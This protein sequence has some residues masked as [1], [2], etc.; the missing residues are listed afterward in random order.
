MWLGSAVILAALSSAPGA[1]FADEVRLIDAHSQADHE[2]DLDR[3]VPLLDRGGISRVML[4]ARSR[5]DWRDVLALAARHPER[6]ILAFDNVWGG[7]LGGLASG[8]DRIVANGAQGP[9]P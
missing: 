5:R 2:V 1:V 7:S 6:I 4:T 8:T 3:I 9:S